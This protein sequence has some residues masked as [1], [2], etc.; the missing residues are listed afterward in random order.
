MLAITDEIFETRAAI[1]MIWS[2]LLTDSPQRHLYGLL[3]QNQENMK[4]IEMKSR[5]H[6]SMWWNRARP[7]QPNKVPKNH[8]ESKDSF[9]IC[10]KWLRW[11][12]PT[13]LA[14]AR[15]ARWLQL[16]R[17]SFQEH[18]SSLSWLLKHWYHLEAYRHAHFAV[19]NTIFTFFKKF[20]LVNALSEDF[21]HQT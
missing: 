11:R 13:V 15:R 2:L 6:T 3:T 10:S 12:G 5:S 4:Y 9:A 21:V 1:T 14:A 16:S 7:T 20:G 18:F 17:V 8:A 19:A